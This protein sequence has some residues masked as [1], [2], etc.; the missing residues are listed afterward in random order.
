MKSHRNVP[1]F[2]LFIICVYPAV[3]SAVLDLTTPGSSGS[4]GSAYY[5]QFEADTTGTGLIDPFLNVTP[6]APGG[7]KSIIQGY[8]TDYNSR[9]AE[10][11]EDEGKSHE[12]LLS[13]VPSVNIGGTTYWEFLLDI[14]ENSGGNNSLLSL[15]DLRLFVSTDSDLTGFSP[16]TNTFSSGPSTLI[17]SFGESDW[18]KL[19]Y[20]ASSGSGKSDM[21]AH[22]PG[23]DGYDAS[24]N[25]VY[26]YCKF[27]EQGD[28]SNG[29]AENAGFEEWSVS[30]GDAFIPAPAAIILGSIG[31]GCV[32]L[33]R[34]R[35]M[36]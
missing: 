3:S 1:V 18:I 7:Q 21:V 17:Y 26:L 36:I 28:G 4:V 5:Y 8:N 31:I 32:N 15:D 6:I 27:G 14:N 24:T 13:A 35:R 12:L 10:Y 29:L 30:K 20:D 11:D 34:R 25:Y 2:A 19:D 23:F 16:G 33:L 9:T 22:I